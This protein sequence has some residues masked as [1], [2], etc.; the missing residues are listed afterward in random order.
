MVSQAFR[1]AEP[2]VVAAYPITPQTTIIEGFAKFVADGDV[3]TEF[4]PTESEHSAMSACIGASAA[5]ARVA[6]ATSSQGLALMWEELYIA[7]GMRLPIVLANANRALS[8]PINIG[9][10]HGDIMGVRDS[11]WIILMAE[12]AQEAYDNSLMAFRIAED[13]RI[14]NPVCTS[15]DGFVT[16][17][18]MER[19]EL[20]DDESVKAFVGGRTP[21]HA[22]LDLDN[23]V[24]MGMYANSQPYIEAKQAQR[25]M[26]NSAQPVIQEIGDEWEKVCGRP[27]KTVDTW[28]MEDAEKAIVIL[29]SCAGNA[30]AVAKRLR[31]K[32][33]KVGVVRVRLFRPFPAKDVAEALSG[34]KAIAV[35]DR[36]E[37]MGAQFAPLAEDVCSALYSAGLQIPLKNYLYGL[38]GTDITLDMLEGVYHDLD[39]V[40]A[41]K[42]DSSIKYLGTR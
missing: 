13:P 36:T 2:D 41:G 24:G 35:L 32:G 12:N 9:A 20:L 40:A 19:C 22:L 28:G 33:E 21:E 16:T 26:M 6:T 23:P 3:R 39:D 18:A 8:S 27:F 7:A 14:Q 5:G 38:G 11:G 1:Q 30:R 42:I 25:L 10:D 29:G 4:V 34:V 17:H 15:L 31:A 37:A